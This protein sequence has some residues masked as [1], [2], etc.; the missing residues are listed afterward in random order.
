MRR[1]RWF[2]S[3]GVQNVA[4][5]S[6]LELQDGETIT[7]TITVSQSAEYAPRRILSHGHAGTVRRNVRTGPIEFGKN[8]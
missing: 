1:R 5:E 4:S 8:V 2:Q 3:G 7:G 6:T